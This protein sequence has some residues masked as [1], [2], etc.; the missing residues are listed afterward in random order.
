[1]AAITMKN[2]FSLSIIKVNDIPRNLRNL[3]SCTIPYIKILLEQPSLKKCDFSEDIFWH[4]KHFLVIA[5]IG[6]IDL[7]HYTFQRI[8]R[9]YVFFF[10]LT[11]TGVAV[12]GGHT[13][14]NFCKRQSSDNVIICKMH[15]CLLHKLKHIC[16]YKCVDALLRL[17]PCW[18]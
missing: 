18:G 2:N 15:L 13:L 16:L 11:K 7:I 14:Q 9:S 10:L 17:K 3:N 8:T 5:W 12:F 1:M 6:N 4:V